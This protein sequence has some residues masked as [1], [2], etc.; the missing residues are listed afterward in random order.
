MFVGVLTKPDR[1]SSGERGLV[2]KKVLSGRAFV[3][4]HGYFVVK[5]P[6]QAELDNGTTHAQARKQEQDYFKS[7]EWTGRFPGFEDRLGTRKLQAALAN[8]LHALILR[9]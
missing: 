4:G 6:D 3:K 5:Q 7:I 2:W 9:R 8:K 1:L